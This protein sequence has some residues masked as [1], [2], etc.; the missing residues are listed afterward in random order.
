MVYIDNILCS[1]CQK[2]GAQYHKIKREPRIDKINYKTHWHLYHVSNCQIYPKNQDILTREE[3]D[4][5]MN[6]SLFLCD[7]YSCLSALMVIESKGELDDLIVLR[8]TIFR[9]DKS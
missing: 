8:D 2:N 6:N 4:K 7:D 5:M 3:I 9:G 1:F